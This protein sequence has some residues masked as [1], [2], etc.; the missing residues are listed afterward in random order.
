[1]LI[2]DDQFALLYESD[3]LQLMCFTNGN[4]LHCVCYQILLN[5]KLSALQHCLRQIPLSGTP[6]TLRERNL[7]TLGKRFKILTTAAA[8]PRNW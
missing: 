8:T 7:T 4:I 3:T 5:I 6:H 2:C 1:M